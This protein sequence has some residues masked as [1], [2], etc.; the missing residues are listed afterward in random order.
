[1]NAATV[2]GGSRAAREAQLLRSATTTV[3]VRVT[4]AVALVAGAVALTALMVS[5]H[6][7]H[8]AAEQI[9][10]SAWAATRDARAPVP[11]TSWVIVDG[12]RGRAATPGA[13]AFLAAL[14][15]VALG[16]GFTRRV[17]AGHEL[18]VYTRDKDIGRVSA[19]HD[20]TSREREAPGLIR[21]VVLAML[22]GSVGAVVVGVG[23]ARQAVRPFGQAMAMQRRFV[24]DVSHELRSPLT[25]LQLRAHM[26]DSHLPPGASKEFA[27]NLRRLVRDAEAT[28]EV[29][30]DLL[31]SAQF[32]SR[33]EAGQEVEVWPV[34]CDVVDSLRPLAD[35][36]R[37][38]LAAELTDDAAGAPATV[39]GAPAALRRAVLALVDNAIQHSAAAGDVSATVDVDVE[40]VM[41]TVRDDGP[42]IDLAEA[43]DVFAR[44]SRGTSAG[45][46]RR[47]GLGLALVDEVAR[48]HGGS[49]EVTNRPGEGAAF[50]LRLPRV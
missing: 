38:R 29:V 23:I 36:R 3:A 33:P 32:E 9:S 11:G 16:D 26:L 34:V 50:T 46:E 19:V 25:V 20:L 1:M 5:E 17:L 37:V 31:R 35:Q 47:F 45:K 8:Q 48:A 6:E 13:P 41:I 7:E 4:L 27:A 30:M 18:V 40:R 49:I 39:V 43:E 44:F 14:D 10:R 21:S 15:P 22:V 24:T 12:P 42:G 28:G 2:P